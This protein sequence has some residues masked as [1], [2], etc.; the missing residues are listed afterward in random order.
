M[1]NLTV[2]LSRPRVPLQGSYSVPAGSVLL[3]YCNVKIK[4]PWK[5]ALKN[6]KW[7]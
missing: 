2:A 1:S 6:E 7:S 5:G 3:F 4:N